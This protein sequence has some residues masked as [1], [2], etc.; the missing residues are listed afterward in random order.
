MASMLVLRLC[1]QR[2]VDG[3]LA[4]LPINLLP[5]AIKDNVSLSGQSIIK[6]LLDV[7]T[8]AA[9]VVWKREVEASQ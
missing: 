3:S 9:V 8:G 5:A 1:L 2:F 4:H 6:N 7:V